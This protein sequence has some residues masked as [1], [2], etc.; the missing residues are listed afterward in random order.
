MVNTSVVS[1]VRIS[2]SKSTKTPCSGCI[3]GKAQQS[4]IPKLSTSKTTGM[5]ELAHSNVLGP[6]NAPSLGGSRYFASFI[7]E[8]SHWTTI[9]TLKKKSEVLEYFRKYH[10]LS[11]TYTGCKLKPLRSDNGGEYLSTPFK[12][13]LSKNGIKHQLTVHHTPH[14]NGVAER[15]DRTLMNLV[16][17]MVHHKNLDKQMWAEALSTGYI[18]AIGSPRKDCQHR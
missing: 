1:G 16:R 10:M 7:D 12:T 8:F 15:M 11:E 6:V 18:F 14:Q 4:N 17:S 9:Y 13:Y 3:Y 5:L 2:G